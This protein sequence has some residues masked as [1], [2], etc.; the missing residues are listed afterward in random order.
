MTWRARLFAWFPTLFLLGAVS[1]GVWLLLRPGWL[2]AL[3]LLGHLYGLPPLCYRLHQWLWPVRDGIYRLDLP[4]HYVPWW[5]GHML[6]LPYHAL[7]QLEAVLRLIPGLYSLWLRAWGAR[8][9][10]NVYWTPQVDITDRGLLEVGDHSILGHKTG[11]YA[12]VI[13]QRDDGMR[14]YV[15]RIRIGRQV[16]VGA[17][18]RLGP[19]TRIA[20]G[21]CLPACTDLWAGGRRS[22]D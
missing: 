7:P 4:Q 20:D 14:L 15:R 21:T 9:G 2:P 11:C 17:G 8:I 12:H 13:V 19:G 22:D 1:L 18:S 16:M 5:G 3:L 10:R 6:Q